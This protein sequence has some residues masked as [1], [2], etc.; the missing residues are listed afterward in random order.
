VFD[1]PAWESKMLSQPNNEFQLLLK[2]LGYV[3]THWWLLL[4]EVCVIYGYALQQYYRTPSEYESHASILIDNSRRQLYQSYV[5]GSA[6][7]ARKQNMAHLLTSQEVLERLR[8]QLTDFYNSEGRP[9]YLRVFFPGSSALPAGALRNFVSISWDRNSDIYNLSCSAENPDAAHDVCLA[10]MDVVQAYYPEIGQR[11]AMMKTEFL[12]RQIASLTRQIA[13]RETNLVDFQ[14]RSPEF[15]NF[16]IVDIEGQGRVKLQTEINA[17]E[18]KLETNRATKRLML[19]TPSAKRGEHSALTAAISAVTQQLTDLQYQLQLTEQSE[20]ANKEARIRT[21]RRSIDEKSSMLARMNDQ[22]V[23]AFMKNPLASED[24]RAKVKDL[25]VEYRVLQIRK[26]S[27]ELRVEQLGRREK[28][29]A[30]PRLEFDRLNTELHH[31]RKLLQSLYTKEQ[32]TALELSAG[33]AEIYRLA[34]PVRNPERVAPHLA[35]YLY[36]SLSLCLFTLAVTIVLLMALFP[37]LDSEAEVN[38][39]NLPV[40]GKVPQMRFKA[41]TVEELPSFGLEHL[42]IMNY[43]ILRETKDIPCPVIIVTSP[44]AREGKSTVGHCMAI[45]A[46]A[47]GR[48]VLLIDG[49][50]LTSRP[51]RFFGIHEDQTAGTRGLIEMDEKTFDPSRL[52]VKTLHDGLAFM[53]R[54]E[55]IDPTSLPKFLQPLEAVLPLLRKDFD[56]IIID[57]PPLFASDLAHQWAG[58]ADLIVVVARLFVTR[59]RDITEAIQTCKIFSRA[60][61]GIALNCVSL[62]GPYRRAANYYFSRKKAKPTRLAA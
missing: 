28:K 5:I 1:P 26:R 52:I 27:L 31:Q 50:L 41:E 3:R 48:R 56:L 34:E 35:G 58:V 46:H 9:N 25:E 53:P 23:Q 54:G 6:N 47:P 18:D 11:E 45:A 57:T 8:N 14:K 4:L 22:E 38:R 40:I 32:E 55:R 24:V 7:N 16:L 15:M 21:L 20:D 2:A 42:K 44:H 60:P 51:N 62:T 19:E 13:E 61:V 37:R 49:D 12:R 17:I 39:L 29:F 30:Q 10:Y 59:P 43:R 36:G 33:N